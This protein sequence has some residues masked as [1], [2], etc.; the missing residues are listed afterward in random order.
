MS[1]ATAVAEEVTPTPQPETT[2][3]AEGNLPALDS[4]GA[5]EG[6]PESDASGSEDVEIDN[7]DDLP[8]WKAL[9]SQA[10]PEE[11]PKVATD[12]L[13]GEDVDEVEARIEQQ[14][15]LRSARI[16]QATDAHWR[17]FMQEKMGLSADEATQTWQ[18]ISPYF[19]ALR[20]GN[21]ALNREMFHRS[22]E[23]ALPPESAEAF[24]SRS[25]RNQR[26]AT[27]AVFEL[28][29]QKERAA[30]EAKLKKG[31]LATRDDV[32]KIRDAAWSRG[33]GQREQAGEV[34]GAE[35]G[36]QVRGSASASNRRIDPDTASIDE[37]NA[38]LKKAGL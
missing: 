6:N 22:V 14:T 12:E 21:A 18:A 25:Y 27:A 10:D 19:R 29:A 35:S 24:Y 4:T 3:L 2:P 34:A 36:Q 1:E 5:P 30:W 37:V 26:E 33:R 15:A 38:M 13:P 16:L 7:P 32:K 31:E 23:A 9:G 28:G 17:Q 11:A 20:D 8:E